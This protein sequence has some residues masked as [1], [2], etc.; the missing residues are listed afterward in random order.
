MQDVSCLT[1]VSH[2]ACWAA[3]AL[4]AVQLWLEVLGTQNGMP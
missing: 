2:A 4:R 1:F 3:V